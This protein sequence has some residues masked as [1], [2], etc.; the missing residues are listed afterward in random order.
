MIYSLL[1]FGFNDPTAI[2]NFSF[3]VSLSMVTLSCIAFSSGRKLT[4]GIGIKK[5][6][7]LIAS[8]NFCL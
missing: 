8:L 3:W 6:I 5:K 4:A 1:P 7:Q 2:D